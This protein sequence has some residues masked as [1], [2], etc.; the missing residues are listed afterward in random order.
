MRAFYS[1]EYWEPDKEAGEVIDAARYEGVKLSL[2][3]GDSKVVLLVKLAPQKTG[4]PP[5]A[6]V[7]MLIAM[8]VASKVGAAYGQCSSSCDHF[9]M[10]GGV[11]RDPATDEDEGDATEADWDDVERIGKPYWVEQAAKHGWT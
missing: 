11:M 2:G 5:D 8:T 6:T 10:D 4:E 9:V 1:I 7:D 3:S